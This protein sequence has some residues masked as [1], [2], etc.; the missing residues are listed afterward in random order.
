MKKINV[1]GQQL[2]NANDE[3]LT[4]EEVAKMM[5]V[6]PA[7]IRKRVQRG[8]IPSYKKPGSKRRWFSKVELIAYIKS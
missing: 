4:V 6:K 3:L 2:I 5:K 1:L 7:S 8:T